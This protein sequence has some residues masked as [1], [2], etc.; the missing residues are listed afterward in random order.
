MIFMVYYH[1]PLI[2][3]SNV[4]KYN[5]FIAFPLALSAIFPQ[6]AYAMR[7]MLHENAR[8][9]PN[10]RTMWEIMDKSCK[11]PVETA[12]NL[13]TDVRDRIRDAALAGRARRARVA[14]AQSLRAYQ[15][16]VR[17]AF[18]SD[19]GGLPQPCSG[20]YDQ[21]P[22]EL[23]F[24]FFSLEKVILHPAQGV[25]VSANV[26]LPQK[27]GGK[28]PAVLLTVGHTDLGKADMEYQ[29]AAQMLA[30]AGFICLVTD[31]LGEGERFE[32]YEAGL[33]LQPIQ[34]C[35]GEHD[36]LDWKAKLMGISLARYFIRDGMAALSYLAA[37]QD[38]D[39]NRIAVTGHSGGG[40]QTCMLMLAAGDKLACAAPCAYV[41][42]AEAM[43]ECGVDPDNEMLW[44]GSLAQGLDYAD[45]IAGMAPKPVLILTNQHDFF[46]REGTLR[47]LDEVGRLWQAAGSGASPEIATA[48]SGHAYPEALAQSMTRFF[49]RHL[50]KRDADLSGFVF[51][52][53]DEKKLRCSPDGI[54]LK[55]F[56]GM[57]T[58]QD[59]LAD[60]LAACLKESSGLNGDETKAA[61]ARA[62]RLEGL[63]DAPEARVFSEGICG[64]LAYRSVI[65]R[66]EDHYWNAGVF[67]R[68]M[69]SGDKP[70]PTVVALWPEGMKR[71][72]EHAHFIHQALENGYQVLVMDVTGEGS[73]LPSALGGSDMYISWST[74]YKLNAYL[75]ELG[76]SLC[77]MR[78]RQVVAAL[79]MLEK[80]PETDAARVCL[81]ALGEYGRYAETASLLTE[82]PVCADG[83]YQ[84]YED[85]VSKRYHDQ[86]NTHEWAFPGVLHFLSTKRLHEFIHMRGLEAPDPSAPRENA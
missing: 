11:L 49:S 42:D 15:D 2:E 63:T 34:G 40:T 73:L 59:E 25:C 71:M 32:H 70:L 53:A 57:R 35:S 41:T 84:P 14:D 26:Y 66:P 43:A 45:F 64:H 39:E 61:A 31:P 86:T 44:P 10:S 80:W 62:L 24:P 27:R 65:W 74:M 83:A 22:E 52:P 30:Y 8:L 1:P 21:C 7:S 55:A 4:K 47:T 37:R 46:P 9:L 38:V 58:V 19:I 56:P 68:D 77:A 67:L 28:C 78:T 17:A 36:L 3:L 72:T 18:L 79:R 20:A 16:T 54:L 48:C 12:T 50:F 33:D 76:D 82:T 13:Y 51:E 23:A 6:E 75:I 5:E 81:Y 69:R 85:I 60:K 29:R